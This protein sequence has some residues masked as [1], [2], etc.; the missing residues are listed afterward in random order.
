M[1]SP[2]HPDFEK[3]TPREQVCIYKAHGWKT[4]ALCDEFDLT[5]AKVRRWT[6]SP[7]A[8]AKHAA[9]MSAYQKTDGARA[10]NKVRC[11]AAYQKRK[12]LAAA[13]RS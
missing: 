3:L 2:D 7:E 1:I 4:S 5:A 13:A 8:K 12:A 10:K 6:I 9:R 11:K